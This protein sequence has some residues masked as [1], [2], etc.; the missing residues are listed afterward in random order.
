MS[1][2]PSSKET[3]SSVLYED[4]EIT[5]TEYDPNKPSEYSA[6]EMME[7]YARYGCLMPLIKE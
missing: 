2:K 1:V 5:I 3:D 6:E 7:S 4:N